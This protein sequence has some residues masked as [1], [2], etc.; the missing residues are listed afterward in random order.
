MSE[1]ASRVKSAF[2]SHDALPAANLPGES[3]PT[4][5]AI[6]LRDLY[7]AKNARVRALAASMT[8]FRATGE[9][10]LLSDDFA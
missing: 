6:M 7:A 9:E 2:A 5:T 4:L 3:D 10:D 8:A 1:S